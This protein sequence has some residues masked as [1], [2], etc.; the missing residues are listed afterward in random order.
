MLLRFPFVTT[1]NHLIAFKS[2]GG[3]KAKLGRLLRSWNWKIEPRRFRKH[4]AE[5]YF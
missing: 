3:Q 1:S 4:I 5:R 2:R